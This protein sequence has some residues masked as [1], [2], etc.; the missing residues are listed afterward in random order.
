[1]SVS[2]LFFSESDRDQPAPRPAG[3]V[4]DDHSCSDLVGRYPMGPPVSQTLTTLTVLTQMPPFISI[5][6][7]NACPHRPDLVG[8]YPMGPACVTTADDADGPDANAGL[9]FG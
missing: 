2:G 4:C 1:V 6:R 9:N 7:V 5:N 8:R 3:D